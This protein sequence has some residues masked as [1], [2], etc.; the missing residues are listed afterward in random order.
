VLG[1]VSGP[2]VR[3]GRDRR[4]GTASL[5]V[6]GLAAAL[7]AALL[8]ASGT[9]LGGSGASTQ[10][11]QERGTSLA[12]REHAALLELYAAESQLAR[13][14][15]AAAEVRAQQ[16]A[17]ARERQSIARRATIVRASLRATQERIGQ[18]LRA[19]YMHGQPDPIAIFLGASSIDEAITSLDSI[20][21]SARLNRRLL[22]ELRR[23]QA[24]VAAAERAL[25]QRSREL[26]AAGAAA[27]AGERRLQRAAA[28]R[29]AL[30]S[31]L[32]QQ[33]DVTN[34]M[35]LQL[36]RQ[37]RAAQQRSAKVA[38]P[39]APA[40]SVSATATTTVAATTSTP[41][42]PA[43][44]PA[45]T[46]TTTTASGDR[47]LVVD[48][49]AYHLPGR[50][51]SGLPVGMGVIAVDPRVIPLGTRVFVPGYGPAVAADTGTAI[52]GNIIDLWFPTTAQAR[53]WGRRTVTIT[54]YG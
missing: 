30:V 43:P 1:S 49:V 18:A 44:A 37:A 20:T 24:S 32:R 6:L 9:A 39:P 29:A 46:S 45:P 19:L 2:A 42:A 27:V 28:D 8:S 48:A 15:V 36:E 5:L 13:A 4:S 51:A 22:A 40:T 7:T 26:V 23:T 25:A 14:R 31:S 12:H 11:L 41:P 52:I 16:T 47:T 21:R 54:I 38:A 34:R 33:R 35:L 10:S 17:I 53:A 3:S 50:T